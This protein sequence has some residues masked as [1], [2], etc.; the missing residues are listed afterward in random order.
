MPPDVSL[1]PFFTW[2]KD[3]TKHT[4]ALWR[5][6]RIENHSL[7]NGFGLRATSFCPRRQK[8]AK[9]PLGDTPRPQ[10]ILSVLFLGEPPQRY[11][12]NQRYI[13]GHGPRLWAATCFQSR[14]QPDPGGPWAPFLYGLVLAVWFE[15]IFIERKS[16]KPPDGSFPPFLS[17]RKGVARRPNLAITCQSFIRSCHKAH[18][19]LW[20]LLS[21]CGE[22]RQRRR[23]ICR[24]SPHENRRQRYHLNHPIQIGAAAPGVFLVLIS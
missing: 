1:H 12:K 4:C 19:V 6:E 15:S 23:I 13:R 24:F 14:A 18:A 11:H 22:R 9:P 8:E 3:V 5:H 20:H 2:R 7:L 17:P 21:L 16:T 10:V